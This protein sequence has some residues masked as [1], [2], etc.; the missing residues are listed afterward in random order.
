MEELDTVMA[1][2]FKKIKLEEVKL[3]SNE[4]ENGL[5]LALINGITISG[6]AK[7]R[8]KERFNLKNDTEVDMT[9]REALKNSK[10]IG[11]VHSTDGTES[12]LYAHGSFGVHVTT[13]Y[14]CVKTL[15]KYGEMYISEILN[16][17][18][19]LKEQIINIQL[20]E[21][22]K[23]NRMRKKL[24]KEQ[25]EGML[26]ANI[27]IAEIE[28]KIYKSKSEKVIQMYLNR[29]ELLL[30]QIKDREETLQETDKKIRKLGGAL[31][32]LYK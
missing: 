18:S 16:N 25:V 31:A 1:D 26:T 11:N 29:K 21:I 9:V 8:G 12:F 32:Y 27:E 6:H 14:K 17:Y 19:D 15:V 13:D 7:K 2:A 20:K 28:M 22:R 23:L 4:L 24:K 30:G 10:F 3:V 5:T